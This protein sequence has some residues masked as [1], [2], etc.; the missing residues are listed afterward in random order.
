MS[1]P[2]T[3]YN[4]PRPGRIARTAKWW[5]APDPE[6]ITEKSR[7]T[8]KTFLGILVIALVAGLV[9]IL[10]RPSA[11]ESSPAAAIAPSVPPILVTSDCAPAE[12][13]DLLPEQVV[14]AA[15][16]PLWVRDGTMAR[17]TSTTGGPFSGDPFPKCFARTPEGALYAATSFATG[18]LSA[19]DSGDLKN[20]FEVRASHTGNYTVMIANLPTLVP[21]TERV[22][23]AITGYRWNNYTPDR[24]SLEIR[25]TSNTG[26]SAGRNAATVYTLTWE[27]NDW[28]IVVPGAP[29]IVQVPVDDGRTY[30]P[31]GGTG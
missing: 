20:F 30:I 18:V 15:F 31:W 4:Q 10:V 6:R 13:V 25:F 11:E 9:V 16:E 2:P 8:S 14:S 1:R 22:Q 26:E 23:V 21:D 19:T 27:N 17:P 24:V 29:D 28:L 3:D 7:K 12:A 5:Y